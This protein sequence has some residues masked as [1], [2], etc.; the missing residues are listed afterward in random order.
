MESGVFFTAVAASGL[1]IG[2]ALVTVM[3]SDSVSVRGSAAP[4][5]VPLSVTVNVKGAGPPRIVLASGA[6]L[7]CIP[8][9]WAR[10]Y[11]VFAVTTVVPSA[12]TTVPR[13]AGGTAVTW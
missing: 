12:S 1:A 7:N 9:I 6:V 13:D 11:V 5:V 4:L 8:W 3:V 10:V 2:A